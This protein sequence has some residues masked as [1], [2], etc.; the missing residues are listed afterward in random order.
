MSN[1]NI[2]DIDQT[3]EKQDSQINNKKLMKKI[4]YGLSEI[5][6]ELGNIYD[7][8]Q[9]ISNNICENGNKIEEQLIKI[10][11]RYDRKKIIDEDPYI[12]NHNNIIDKHNERVYKFINK[13]NENTYLP[14][15]ENNENNEDYLFK[16]VD[17]QK[18]DEL[19]HKIETLLEDYYNKEKKYNKKI[20]KLKKKIK[21][22]KN[23]QYNKLIKI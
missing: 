16:M 11:N 14:N 13:Q 17:R 21:K 15:I 5:T 20:I 9:S 22:L 2:E 18:Y 1:N 3:N 8:L 10:T 19:P 12:K 6:D 4:I 7:G 23:N